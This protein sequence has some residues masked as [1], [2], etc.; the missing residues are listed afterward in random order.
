MT[1]VDR[2]T[3][4]RR[5]R[6]WRA[7]VAGVVAAGAAL[8]AGE[9]P[10]AIA[11]EQLG[12]VTTVG[13]EFVDRFAASLKELAIALFGQNDKVALVVGIVVISLL[14]GAALGLL[15]LRS[16]ALAAA[17]FVAFALVGLA[18]GIAD[19]STGLAL[20]V[21]A[22]LAGAVAGVGVLALLLAQI[23]RGPDLAKTLRGAGDVEDPRIRTPDRRTFLAVGAAAV[24][25][26]R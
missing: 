7:A 26:P 1:S 14:L 21:V 10:G 5:E 12:P 19:A 15:A 2:R 4:A 24:W 23:G 18:A 9:L 16:F 11:G 13:N 20:P 25:P 3:S 8:A 6:R 17:G 22:A